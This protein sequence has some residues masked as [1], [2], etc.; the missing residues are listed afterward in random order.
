[1]NSFIYLP[2]ISAY[3]QNCATI[4]S[5]YFR[6]FHHLN[7]KLHYT[8]ARLLSWLE[9][10]PKHQ[11]VVGSILS[12]GACRRHLP[13][14][15]VY[16]FLSHISLSLSVFPPSLS[17]FSPLK[18]MNNM[19]SSPQVGRVGESQL[20]I[21]VRILTNVRIFSG[22]SILFHRFICLFLFQYHTAMLNHKNRHYIDQWSIFG[23]QKQTLTFTSNRFLTRVQ[24]KYKERLLG[25]CGQFCYF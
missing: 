3:I 11:N 13:V 8:L 17:S 25:L 23:I 12:Q 9:C 10:C 20:T 1:M 19:S 18:L 2:L 14:T 15:P 7:K 24:R 6:T 5:L 21:N 16:V 4:I 22:F